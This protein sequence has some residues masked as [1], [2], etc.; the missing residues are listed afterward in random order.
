M[1]TSRNQRQMEVHLGF[2]LIPLGRLLFARPCPFWFPPSHMAKLWTKNLTITSHECLA[3]TWHHI[4]MTFLI[5]NDAVK[6]CSNPDEFILGRSLDNQFDIILFQTYI[7]INIDIYIYTSTMHIYLAYMNS[8][9]RTS[10]NS[11][12]GFSPISDGSSGCP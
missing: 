3:E 8:I 6:L 1:N 7:F 2:W 9:T 5:A 12:N 11:N 10:M 4:E